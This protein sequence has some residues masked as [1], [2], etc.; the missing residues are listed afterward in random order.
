MTHHYSWESTRP[1]IHL[2]R[3]PYSILAADDPSFVSMHL[4]VFMLHKCGLHRSLRHGGLY[5]AHSAA[6][7]MASSTV[8]RMPVRVQVE[9]T[10]MCV[11]GCKR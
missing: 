11:V 7:Y 6:I 10:A 2:A 3:H 4:L 1:C 8:K 5:A 9:R